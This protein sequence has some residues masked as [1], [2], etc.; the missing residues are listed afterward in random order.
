MRKNLTDHTDARCSS[1]LFQATS[2][3]VSAQTQQSQTPKPVVFLR[4]CIQCEERPIASPKGKDRNEF[5][6]GN[7]LRALSYVCMRL[8]CVY[9]RQWRYSNAQLNTTIDHPEGIPEIASHRSVAFLGCDFFV[10]MF[11]NLLQKIIASQKSNTS[12]HRRMRLSFV[13]MFANLLQKII[14]SQ[15]SNTSHHRRMRLSFVIMFANL[16]QKIIASQKSNTSH[17]RR[18]RLSAAVRNAQLR[19]APSK[20]RATALLAPPAAAVRNANIERAQNRN[21]KTLR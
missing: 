5:C 4:G 21:R 15:K 12:H 11:A 18:M 13:I 20:L 6:N 16:L 14:A 2:L 9:F 19:S 1:R 10:I 17:H 3:V 7:W 8:R